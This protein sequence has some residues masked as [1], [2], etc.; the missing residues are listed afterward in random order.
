MKFRLGSL[1]LES[2]VIL[3]PLER[4][5]DVGFRRL[6]FQNGAALTWTEMV[7]ASDF[8]KGRPSAVDVVDTHDADTLTGCQFLVDRT[9]A[10]DN[11][12]VDTLHR[13]LEALER[14]ASTDRPEWNNIVAIDLN[15]GCPSPELRKRGAG[16]SQLRRR[17]KISNLFEALSKWK[18]TTSLC[19]IQAVGAKIRLGMNKVEQKHKVYLPVADAAAAANLDYLVVHARNAQQRSSDEPTWDAIGEVKQAVL[20]SDIKIIGNGNVQNRR[21]MEKMIETTKCDGVMVA[22]SAMNNPWGLR[23]FMRGNQKLL[24]TIDEFEESIKEYMLWSAR[25]PASPRYKPFHDE[26]FDRIR[27]ELHLASREK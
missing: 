23:D 27:R 6:C 12:G 2:N 1:A 14:G 15:F 21:D 5:S 20:S 4:V 18:A 26:N 8:S 17:S 16:P 22:R 13:A 9:T 24:P 11:W 7:Y 10:K 25:R 3:A 19:N